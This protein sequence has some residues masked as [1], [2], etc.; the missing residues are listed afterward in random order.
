MKDVGTNYVK[1]PIPEAEK[2]CFQ[3][4]CTFY[5]LCNTHC[6]VT[7]Y[8]PAK[9]SFDVKERELRFSKKTF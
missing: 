1:L 8:I 4:R 6:L 9:F 7:P 3:T 5:S 2:R